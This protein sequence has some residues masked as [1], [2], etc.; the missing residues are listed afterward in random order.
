MSASPPKADIPV[1]NCHVRFV[2]KAD[3]PVLNC[4]V[5]FVPIA[6]VNVG[7]QKPSKVDIT[8]AMLEPEGL[9]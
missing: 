9:E 1:L 3:I 4:H 5:H 2:P 6:D 7:G 8:P